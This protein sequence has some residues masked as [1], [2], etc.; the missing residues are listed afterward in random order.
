MRIYDIGERCPVVHMNVCTDD[1]GNDYW[2]SFEACSN[3]W[4]EMVQ[5]DRGTYWHLFEQEQAIRCE[6]TS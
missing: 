3:E 6:A 5:I 1:F 2:A 4:M